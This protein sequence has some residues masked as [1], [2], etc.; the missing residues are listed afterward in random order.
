VRMSDERITLEFLAEQQRR[1]IDE[2][3]TLRDEVH[4]QGAIVRRLDNTNALLL[5]ELRAI[6]GL[7]ARLVE[8]V[9]TLEE[10]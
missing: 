5:E 7:L 2:I 3:G 8:R 9:R 10:R 6:H 1:I 4:V